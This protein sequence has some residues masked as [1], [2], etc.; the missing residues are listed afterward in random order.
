MEHANICP[1]C[2]IPMHV[3]CRGKKSS[4]ITVKQWLYA[5]EKCKYKSK[6]KRSAVECSELFLDYVCTIDVGEN[7]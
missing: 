3:F 6:K 4:D 1:R 7:S 2:H 5:C